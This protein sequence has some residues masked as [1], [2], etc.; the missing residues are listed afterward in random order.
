MLRAGLL[1]HAA[2]RG[3]GS[4]VCGLKALTAAYQVKDVKEKGAPT[5]SLHI[6][7]QANSFTTALL[8]LYYSC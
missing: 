8:Q 4:R 7:G 3:V 5:S 2:L 1:V 6:A